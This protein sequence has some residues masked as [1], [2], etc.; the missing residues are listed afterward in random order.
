[1]KIL[2]INKFLYPK[3]GDA[4]VTLAT[5][6]LLEKKGHSVEYWGMADD[7]NKNYKFQ[8]FF[9][10]IINYNEKIKIMQKIKALLNILYS[11][12]A[13]DKLEKVL[14]KWQPD[15]VHLHNFAH[16][17]SPSIL[18]TI[19]KFNIPIV[20]TMHDYK[21]VCPVYALL[22][23]GE[24][25]EK[26]KNGHYGNCFKYKCAKNSKAKS[27]VNTIEMVLHHKLLDIYDLVDI[28]ISPSQFLIGKL[29]EMGF[30]KEIEYIPNFINVDEYKPQYETKNNYILY[31]GR[32]SKEKGIETLVKAMQGIECTLKILG[33]GSLATE[34][35][36]KLS[37]DKINNVELLGYKT[38][39]ELRGIIEK[40]KFV[41]VPSECYENNPLSAIEA[42][43]LG[44]PVIGANIG[45][46]P[47]IVKDEE[48]GYLFKCKDVLM[49]RSKIIELLNSNE[50]RIE[51][52]HNAR[53]FVEDKMNENV[54]YE[55]LMN[56]Y[57]MAVERN[58]K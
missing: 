36:E 34:I 44:K 52:G 15:I 29:H 48:T 7:K 41:V 10:N 54:Y 1:M 39:D 46:I 13:K 30:K 57:N 8:E 26:C 2:Q 22:N 38:G 12:E 35:K 55:K 27:F 45:G 3:G 37:N 11:F 50:K 6:S 43:A 19:K 17:I 5:G 14:K 58:E 20:M 4:V 42:F 18:H 23:S 25:C 56:V 21:L 40:S 9:V 49:L 51:M 47:E 33:T 28:F 53:K 24:V 32:I 16:Q 31:C